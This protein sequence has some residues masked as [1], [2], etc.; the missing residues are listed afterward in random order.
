VPKNWLIN[1]FEEI[2]WLDPENEDYM[3]YKGP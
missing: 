1:S 2:G 3:K